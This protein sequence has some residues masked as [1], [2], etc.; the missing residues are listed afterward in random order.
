MQRVSACG[1]RSDVGVLLLYSEGEID[2][3][4]TRWA[5]TWE[6]EFT[7]S[8]GPRLVFE[9][10]KV[11]HMPDVPQYAD[12]MST[13]GLM[14]IEVVD[15]G[16]VQGMLFD[17]LLFAP[18]PDMPADYE[19]DHVWQLV[20]WH[21]MLEFCLKAPKS[22]SKQELIAVAGSIPAS[23]TDVQ[24]VSL[25]EAEDL[26][27]IDIPDLDLPAGYETERVCVTGTGSAYLLIS[28]TGIAVPR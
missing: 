12:S 10:K 23:S 8:D 3:N 17:R 25:E 21:S 13:D 4:S 24:E 11:C 22:L 6:E 5:R 2:L 19:T 9:I 28:D 27:D 7:R 20:W 14:E 1:L 15:V 26:L 16:A 18:S